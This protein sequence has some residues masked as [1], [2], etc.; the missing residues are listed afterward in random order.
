[1]DFLAFSEIKGKHGGKPW[2][3]VTT[4]YGGRGLDLPGRQNAN[5]IIACHFAGRSDIVQLAGR[6]CRSFDKYALTLRE[7][8]GYSNSG[9]FWLDMDFVVM[10]PELK[11]FHLVNLVQTLLR[12]VD[13]CYPVFS[14]TDPRALAKGDAWLAAINKIFKEL[15]LRNPWAKLQKTTAKKID[16]Q[17]Q[18]QRSG[19]EVSK[20]IKEFLQPDITFDSAKR[21]MMEQVDMDNE[22]MFSP[23]HGK[24]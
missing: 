22:V 12:V 19:V 4:Q 21:L 6:G 16:L 10:T 1:M 7:K 11:T 14:R 18:A 3:F 8:V 2:V 24:E 23:D 5:V 17:A 15:R 13:C 9:K 20:L